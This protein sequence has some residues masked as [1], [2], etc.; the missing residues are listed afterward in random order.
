MRYLFNKF[1][2]SVRNAVEDRYKVLLNSEVEWTWDICKT[3]QFFLSFLGKNPIK[4]TRYP[5]Q[6][7]NDL[8]YNANMY[9]YLIYAIFI[10]LHN[11]PMAESS[12]EKRYDTQ[13]KSLVDS[14]KYER[15]DEKG[16]KIPAEQERPGTRV[17]Q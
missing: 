2:Q 7:Q 13:F 16:R 17:R 14:L 1:P 6:A 4:N 9:R 5:W 10:K 3:V 11:Y 15:F 12:F 8:L